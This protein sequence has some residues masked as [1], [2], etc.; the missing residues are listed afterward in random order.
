MQHV[1][2]SLSKLFGLPLDLQYKLF[3]SIVIILSLWLIR[4]VIL[5]IAF[6]KITVL[7]IRYK[8]KKTSLYLSFLIGMLIVGRIWIEGLNSLTTFIGLF[9]AGLAIA[10][11]DLVSNIA[12]WL[13]IIGK[14]P[15]EVGDRVQIGSIAGDVIDI[16]IFQFTILEIGNWVDD[17]QSTGRIIH[18]P[19]GQVFQKEIANY[20]KGFQYI[21]NEIPVVI[22]FESNWEKAKNNPPEYRF[23][24]TLK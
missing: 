2:S 21:W 9:S 13:F 23:E 4:F 20:S 19:N 15:L 10:L 8:W 12:G 5:K 22:T 14:R 18:L 16:R 24:K 7:P 11:K 1:F 6:K 17:D 3:S